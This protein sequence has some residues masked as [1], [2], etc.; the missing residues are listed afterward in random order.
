LGREF[1]LGH[2]H[3]CHAH[4]FIKSSDKK[5]IL[6]RDLTP[7]APGTLKSKEEFE[8]NMSRRPEELYCLKQLIEPNFVEKAVNFD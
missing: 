3:F 8:E 4:W 1:E 2:C 7:A 6:V 5:V